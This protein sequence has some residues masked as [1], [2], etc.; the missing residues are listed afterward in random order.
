M[1]K[2]IADNAKIDFQ[3]SLDS[4]KRI[5]GYDDQELADMLGCSRKTI[6]NMRK[7]PFS[8]S[9]RWILMVQGYLNKENTK[10]R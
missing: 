2:S 8:V 10:R 7:D 4:L 9:G 3:I 1:A 6:V 5:R